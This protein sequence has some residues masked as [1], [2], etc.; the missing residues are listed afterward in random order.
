MQEGRDIWWH[1]ENKKVNSDKIHPI[2]SFVMYSGSFSDIPKDWVLCDGNNGTINLSNRFILGSTQESEIFESGGSPDTPLITHT[3]SGTITESGD[4]NHT[5]T[6]TSAGSHGH[7]YSISGSGSHSHYSY[8]S[9][10]DAGDHCGGWYF[11]CVSSM[12]SGSGVPIIDDDVA[13]TVSGGA[14]THSV[15]VNAAGDHTHTLSVDTQGDHNH[16]C[17]LDNTGESPTNKN[18]PPYYKLAFIQRIS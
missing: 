2:E 10:W 5:G 16:T 11:W 15:T 13:H 8:P 3:H 12:Q 14:H 6:V 17:T 1:D 9:D 4:H 18:N 7:G